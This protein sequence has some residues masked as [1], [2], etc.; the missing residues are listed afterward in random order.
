MLDQH[1]HV[2]LSSNPGDKVLILVESRGLICPK[3][4]HLFNILSAGLENN[5]TL[6]FL[7]S[8]FP[9]TLIYMVMLENCQNTILMYGCSPIQGTRFVYLLKFNEARVQHMHTLLR[10][11]S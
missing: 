9:I 8:I 7:F 4:F 11:Y 6:N 10:N 1:F 5:E 3:V 2:L